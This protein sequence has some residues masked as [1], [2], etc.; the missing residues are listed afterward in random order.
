MKWLIKGQ[1]R[2]ISR[3]GNE[4]LAAKHRDTIGFKGCR[5]PL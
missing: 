3:F 2:A 5:Q 4:N 1:K